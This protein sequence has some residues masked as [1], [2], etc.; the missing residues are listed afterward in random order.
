MNLVRLSIAV[1]IVCGLASLASGQTLEE[2]LGLP[3]NEVD[4][5]AECFVQEPEHPP[6]SEVCGPV[7]LASLPW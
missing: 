1:L 6:A 5:D 4:V 7:E 2:K 3:I